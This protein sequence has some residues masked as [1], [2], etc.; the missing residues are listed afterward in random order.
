MDIKT[1]VEKAA[2]VLKN[3]GTILY[4]TDT[5]WGLGC[6][7][8]N[9]KAVEKIFK[10]K[11]RAESKSMIILVD[12]V[13]RIHRHVKTIPEVAY[14]LIDH[15][16]T[17]LTI[18]YPDSAGLAENVVAE[19]GSVAIRVVKDEF[20]RLLI[21]KLNR[22]IVSTSANI[23]NEPTAAIFKEISEAILTDVDYIVN[24]RQDETEK[25]KP[26]SII[27]IKANGEFTIIR[28]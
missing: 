4:P 8:T 2:L 25:A 7:A 28:K 21:R 15:A 17:P 20:C 23:S 11:K 12:N 9:K 14:D 27:K 22:P 10:I 26:S 13:T 6:D 18:I 24:L 16:D 5:V 19:D 3:G 1:E